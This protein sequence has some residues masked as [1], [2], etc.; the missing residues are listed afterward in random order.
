MDYKIYFMDDDGHFTGSADIFAETDEAAEKEA[1]QY[2]AGSDLELWQRARLVKK[3]P[4]PE[5][6]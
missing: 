5:P 3:L 4:R 1:E 2:G 6:S